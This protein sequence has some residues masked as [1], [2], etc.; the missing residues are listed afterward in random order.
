MCTWAVTGFT[1]EGWPPRGRGRP[2]G[3]GSLSKGSLS[4]QLLSECLT[5]THTHAHAH[6]H[7]PCRHPDRTLGF[8]SP[9]L[10]E[11]GFITNFLPK[12]H[13]HS[14]S[15]VP[16]NLGTSPSPSS[17]C[18]RKGCRPGSGRTWGL[19]LRWRK[20][21]GGTT[22]WDGEGRHQHRASRPESPHVC[23]GRGRERGAHEATA[24]SGPGPRWPAW[25]PAARTLCPAPLCRRLSLRRGAASFLQ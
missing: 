19:L 6:T 21:R 25:T 10:P 23:R 22:R 2:A 9:E 24:A 8:P 3:P 20:V 14:L 17:A 18:C 1:L 12:R 7:R 16:R 11:S 4:K 5:H 15:R 13:R